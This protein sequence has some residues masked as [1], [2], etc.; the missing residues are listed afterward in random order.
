V[1]PEGSSAIGLQHAN[2]ILAIL[3]AHALMR[4][5]EMGM[6]AAACLCIRHASIKMPARHPTCTLQPTTLLLGCSMPYLIR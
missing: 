4:L 2:G 5:L 6:S 1:L 3:H